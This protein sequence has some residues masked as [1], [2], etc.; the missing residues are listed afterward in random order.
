[1][2]GS[3]AK[4]KAIMTIKYSPKLIHSTKYVFYFMAFIK[5]LTLFRIDTID[6]AKDK[7]KV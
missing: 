2:P 4:N 1:M 7:I 3:K 6:N 5:L